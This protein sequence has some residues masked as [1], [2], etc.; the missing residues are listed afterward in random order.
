ME[1]FNAI[2][3]RSLFD[4]QEISERR[5]V[6][7][8]IAIQKGIGFYPPLILLRALGGNTKKILCSFFIFQEVQC[9]NWKH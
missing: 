6:R 1:S 3:E 8:Y 7:T 2:S 4:Y 5:I 9:T